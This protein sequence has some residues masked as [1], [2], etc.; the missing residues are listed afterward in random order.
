MSKVLVAVR[1]LRWHG[2][3]I[4]EITFSVNRF[5]TAQY[6][7]RLNPGQ[8]ARLM[9]GERLLM[10]TLSPEWTAA[11][12]EAAVNAATALLNSGY[13]EIFT[14]T[15]PA[16]DAANTGTKAAKLTF[17]VTAFGGSTASGGTVTAT[18]NAITSDS[19]AVGGT[20]GYMALM[21]SD[22]TT[23]V[24][25]GSAGVGASYNL[26]LNSTAISAGATVS[27]SSF[28]ITEPQT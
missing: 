21:K 5:R 26:N 15:Q 16:T 14:G 23:I 1:S 10:A 2:D 28:T 4:G 6:L 25:T 18:A 8:V 19:S 27:C 3:A 22:D 20:A 24:C 7:R 11:T 17:G 9:A 12:V 13:L